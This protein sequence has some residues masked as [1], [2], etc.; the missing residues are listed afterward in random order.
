MEPILKFLGQIVLFGGGATVIAYVL[1]RWLGQKWIEDRFAKRLEEH[2]RRQNVLLEEVR[3]Q[4]NSRFNRITKIHEKEFEI[5][6]QAWIYLR[7]AYGYLSSIASP[8]QSFPDLDDYS[9][10]ELEAFLSK[11]ELHDFQRQ[12]L[13]HTDD[14]ATYFKERIFRIR[15]NAAAKRL[16]TFRLYIMHNKIFLTKDL[17]SAFSSIESALVEAEVILEHTR[18]SGWS[19]AWYET[20]SDEWRTIEENIKPMLVS[21]EQTIQERLHFEPHDP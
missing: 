3:Y 1:V 2:K 5:L 18:E 14:K 7:D 20:V 15:I 13:I 4:I 8:F 6:P 17:F 9:Q 11:S 19:S 21:I 16:R 10:D 12:E